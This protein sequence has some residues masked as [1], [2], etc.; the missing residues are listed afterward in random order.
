M[1]SSKP[2]F[3]PNKAKVQLKML[4]NRLNLLTSK[5]ANLAKVEKRKAAMLLR[6]DKEH[7]ARILVEQIIRDDY[8]LEAYDLIKQYTEMLLARFNVVTTEDELKP[9]I[10]DAVCALVYCGWLMGSEIDELK[11][12]FNLFTAK[13]GKAYTAEVLEH[14]E[15]YI[16]ARLLKIL[17]STQVPDPSVIDA[18]LTE[19]ARAY[20]VEYISKPAGSIQPISATL[21]IALPTPGMPMPGPVPE[22]DLSDVTAPPPAAASG[23]AVGPA[24]PPAVVAGVPAVVMPMPFNLT[25]TKTAVMGFGLQ[26]DMNNV[27]TTI[28]PGSQAASSGALLL[29]DRVIS[30][31]GTA[32]T[33]ELPAKSLCADLDDGAAAN[34][35]L[36]RT[37]GGGMA[38]PHGMPPN[39]AP[40][41]GDGS[42][43]IALPPALPAVATPQEGGLPPPPPL[44]VYPPAQ[45][46]MPPGY[47][48]AQPAMPPVYPPAQS[49]ALP[50]VVGIMQGI[51]PAQSATGFPP[52][53]QPFAPPAPTAQPS[54]S[55]P[56]APS[57]AAPLVEDADD[58]L[59]RRLQALQRG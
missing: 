52:M 33:L 20:G 46:T 57:P 14:K 38:L 9:E 12:L 7:N 3:D 35:T 41:D 32:C 59:A 18:Y 53:A 37:P 51:P 45:P 22:P 28:K 15:K 55:P 19:I 8:T 4:I 50:P 54:D 11:A 13:Y 30:I 17:S 36:L 25:L 27:V 56:I 2:R 48:P 47:P 49:T 23:A 44:G 34:F 42:A 31:N 1:F 39:G 40:S 26:L 21:G 58:L 29:G 10:A 6:E 43:A 24:T 16:N 5:R